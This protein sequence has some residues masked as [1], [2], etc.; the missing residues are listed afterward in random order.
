MAGLVKDDDGKVHRMRF[1]SKRVVVTGSGS[2]IGRSTAEL[3]AVEGA[4][5]V[6]ADIDRAGAEETVAHITAAGGHA[7]AVVVDVSDEGS[8]VDLIKTAVAEFGGLDIMVNNAG[9]ATPSPGLKFEDHSLQDFERLVGVNFR[10]VYLGC[11]EAVKV[12]KS[13]AVGGAIVNTASITGL[14]GT[15]GSVYGATKGAIVQLTRGLAIELAEADI[16]VNCICPG[17]LV[18]TNLVKGWDLKEDL[19][20]TGSAMHPLGRPITAE[21]CANAISFL[22]SD[23]AR[24]IT[25]VAL[26]VDGG[27]VAG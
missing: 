25:G 6:V 16:R 17:A 22:A 10:G 20:T 1:T 24:N 7:V 3:F 19:H 4:K 14:V 21:D 13:Q 27:F 12:F 2:G 8:V 18:G 23:A 9:V 11:R 15:G 26:P 5:V